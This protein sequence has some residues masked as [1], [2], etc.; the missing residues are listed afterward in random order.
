MAL[1]VLTT[2]TVYKQIT[3]AASTG[4]LA[5]KLYADGS[6]EF[7]DSDGVVQRAHSNEF[8]RKLFAEINAIAA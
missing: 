3:G 4:T 2:L 7:T 8:V 5:I 6:Y 1:A